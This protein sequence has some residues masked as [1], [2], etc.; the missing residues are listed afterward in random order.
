MASLAMTREQMKQ[1]ER[2]GEERIP[3]FTA[4]KQAEP[5]SSGWRSVSHDC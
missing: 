4:R 5:P 3:C 2:R 1:I